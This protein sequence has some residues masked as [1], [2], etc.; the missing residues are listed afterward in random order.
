MKKTW[1]ALFTVRQDDSAAATFVPVLY[2]LALL[3]FSIFLTS[4]GGAGS[5]GGGKVPSSKTDERPV[6]NTV[7][8]SVSTA[9]PG[10][11]CPE[12]GI[13]VDT[14]A[15]DNGNGVLEPAEADSTQYACKE[16]Q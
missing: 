6:L 16:R 1:Y 13:R 9:A 14:G 10:S 15:D 11:D 5:G 8:T 7:L 4:C 3:I 2:A 12:G